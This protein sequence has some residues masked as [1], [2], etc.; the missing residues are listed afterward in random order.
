MTN[1]LDQYEAYYYSKLWKLLPAIYQSLDSS[2]FNTSGPLRELVNRIGVQA[3]N[4]R[5]SIDRMWEDQSIETCDDW[6]IP[7]I[8]KLLATNLILNLDARSQRLD[9]ANTIDYRRRKGTLGVLEEMTFNLTG[10]GVKIVE[11]FRRLGRC[12]H[13]LDPEIGLRSVNDGDAA[14]LQQAEQL[15]GPLTKTVIGG[16]AD[17][18]NVNGALKIGTAFDEYF[19]TPDFRPGKGSVGWYDIANLGV[20]LWRLED[21]TVG[22]TTPVQVSG[23]KG[24]YTF[25][26]TGRDIELFSV[27]RESDDYG[28]KW[29]SPSEGQLPAPIGQRLWDSK[30]P[31]KPAASDEFYPS[32]LAI[33]PVSPSTSVEPPP[34]DLSA[35]KVR[36]EKGHFQVKSA[37]T[38]SF[39]VVYTYGFSSEI[40]AGP[41]DRRVGRAAPPAAKYQ[42]T[43]SGGV[44]IPSLESLFPP[45]ALSRMVTINDSLTYTQIPDMMVLDLLILTAGVRQRPILRMS[46]SLPAWTQLAFTGGTAANPS[47]LVLDGLF[48]SGTD[49]VLECDFDCVTI[50]CCTLDPGNVA[51]PP[52]A[53][54]YAASADERPLVPCRIWIEGNIKT[55]NVDRSIVG[56]IATR[57][58][59]KL[60]T[61]NVSNSII[62]A[63]PTMG[64]EPAL[65]SDSLTPTPVVVPAGSFD[66]ALNFAD[67]DVNLSRCTVLG[68]VVVHRLNASECILQDTVIVDNT[69]EGCVRFSAFADGSRLPRQYESVR[70]APKAPLFTSTDFGAAGYCQLSQIVDVFILPNAGPAP[71]SPP[72]IA[73]GAEDGSEMGAFARDRNPLKQQGLL[74]KYQEFMPAALVPVLIY[75]T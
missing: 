39:E 54:L 40:G 45:D 64:V 61:L 5:R 26:P 9:V 44:T 35:V 24:W 29:V 72:T 55:L 31:K 11:F 18:R 71:P 1:D 12:R 53:S 28:D 38:S 50:T 15:V 34:L 74:L 69:Q 32:S 62:Q 33:Y 21:F 13:S 30:I 66:A 16:L 41:Y 22:F 65:P 67:G 49:I 73:A 70:I 23:G 27:S 6:V 42:T 14:T 43:I 47:C 17:L 8:G 2:Q 19:H 37:S 63:I 36:T 48:I 25:D 20:F 10:W 58:Q 51:K 68:P 56:P 7:Y 3:A 57:N 46:P 75:V 4:L 52:S 60:E 59:G